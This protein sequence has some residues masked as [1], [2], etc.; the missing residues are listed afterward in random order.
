MKKFCVF[1]GEKPEGKSKEHIIPQ[2]LIKLTGNQKRIAE[3]GFHNRKGML[4]GKRRYSFDAFRF[5]SCESCNDNFS[6]LEAATKSIVQKML[7]DGSLSATEFSTLLDWFDKIRI[8]LWLAYLYLDENPAGITPRFHVAK[9][10]GVHDR[11]LAI[12]K[13]EGEQEGLNDCGSDMP[14]FRY[15]PSC[16]SLR[17]NNYCFLNMSYNN[18]FSRRIGFPFPTKSFRMKDGQI[19]CRFTQGRNRVMIPILKKRFSIH[20]TELYQ[21]MFPYSIR[22]P[23]ARR[24]HDTKYVRDNSMSWEQGI[25]KVFIQ[26]NTGLQEYP[27]SPSKLWLPSKAYEFEALL[28]EMQLLTLEWQ[29]YIDSLAPSFEMLPNEERR[30]F[31]HNL[32]ANKLHNKEMIRV[33]RKMAKELGMSAPYPIK[34]G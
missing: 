12:F 5:P 30:S 22:D 6:R 8:G 16:F 18:L 19:L 34:V 23:N 2:W 33:L 20:G 3:F 11:M 14:S 15:T 4:S 32:R 28:F 24:L 29:T 13:A 17:I 27:M 9:R 10:I 1:C 26:D 21:P 7:S 31:Q 25:G